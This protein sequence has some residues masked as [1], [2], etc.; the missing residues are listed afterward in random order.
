MIPDK[1]IGCCE[2]VITNNDLIVIF[3]LVIL[4]I[5]YCIIKNKLK[6]KNEK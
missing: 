1:C 6:K 4:A 2:S 5:F 3:I